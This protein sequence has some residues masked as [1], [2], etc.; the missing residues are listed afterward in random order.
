MSRVSRLWRR[1]GATQPLFRVWS[2]ADA[3]FEMGDHDI[4]DITITRGSSGG[5]FGAQEHTL[6]VHTVVSRGS[7]T[8]RPI[9]CDMT[10]YGANL[11]AGLVNSTEANIRPRFFG[12]IGKQTI[13]DYGGIWD[14]SKWRTSVYASKWQ[15]QLEHSDR[16]G[17]Q[18]SGEP[19]TY[20]LDHFLN[21]AR[22][23][24]PYMPA[25]TFPAPA[26]NY[27]FM[28]NDYEL[29]EAKITWADF[30]SKYLD[31]P[32]YYVQ[33]TRAGDD[34]VMTM[35]YRW[36]VA[37]ARLGTAHPLT[38]SAALSPTS[39]EQPHEQMPR[40]HRVYWQDANGLRTAVTGPNPADV[41]IPVQE[42]DLRHIRFTDDTHA[43][44][45]AYAAYG[46]ERY[47]VSYQLPGVTVDQL[48]LLSSDL[49]THPIQAR[50]LLELEMGDP[51][52][53]SGDWYSTTQGI[54]FASGITE[55]ITPD[56]WQIELALTPSHMTVGQWTEDVPPKV[57]DSARYPWDT[58]TE[59]W[60]G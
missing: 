23:D 11:V 57:W 7:R 50:Q 41:R 27:G 42:H 29:G 15:T 40:N 58:A 54:V 25:A 55:R 33:N 26:V 39:W 46:A 13:D 32:G 9:H 8:G 12:R 21:P 4:T 20:L 36:S 34:R 5:V 22:E 1:L 16:V 2:E 52:Y 47:D 60:D 59:P 44:W 28:K 24:M 14:A 18:I 49:P 53:L 6:E 17:N 35:A 48:Y 30:A 37:R 56:S 43:L 45:R 51:V 3:A 19:V 31:G 38:R 10:T